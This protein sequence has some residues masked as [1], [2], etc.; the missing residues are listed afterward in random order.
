MTRDQLIKAVLTRLGQRQ[1]DTKLQEAAVLE[2]QLIQYNQLEGAKFK[3]W[4]LL[5][6]YEQTTVLSGEYKVSLPVRFLEE[7]EEG[8]LWLANDP[9]NDPNDRTGL[10]KDDYDYLTAKYPGEGAIRAYSIAG[11]YFLLSPRLSADTVLQ[12]RYYKREVLM[13]DAYGLPAPVNPENKW[14]KYAADWYMAELGFV[15][16]K[17]YTRDDQSAARFEA[18]K[19]LAQERVYIETIARAEAN[20]NR[21]MGVED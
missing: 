14:T 1:N 11:S 15:L 21:Q 9:V 5:S 13:D 18:D 3:P 20:V 17:H 12:M 19:V 7:W 10:P 2:Q 16:A 4:F 8:S 6:E